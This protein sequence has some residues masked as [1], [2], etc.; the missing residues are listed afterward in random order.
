MTQRSDTD[1][2]IHVMHL[3]QVK[4]KTPEMIA[5]EAYN[6]PMPTVVENP[7]ETDVERITKLVANILRRYDVVKLELMPTGRIYADTGNGDMYVFNGDTLVEI[8]HHV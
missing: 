4:P 7:I 8:R 5:D 3:S 2:V 1:G 6:N